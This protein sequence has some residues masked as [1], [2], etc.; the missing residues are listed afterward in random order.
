[1]NPNYDKWDIYNF[2]KYWQNTGTNESILLNSVKYFK[3]YYPLGMTNN[4][5]K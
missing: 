1:M 4:H 5:A 2:D 3:N